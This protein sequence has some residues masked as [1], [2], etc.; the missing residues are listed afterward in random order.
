MIYKLSCTIWL[1]GQIR[2][3]ARRH[4]GTKKQQK[5][6]LVRHWEGLVSPCCVSFL[7]NFAPLWR[8]EDLFS[9]ERSGIKNINVL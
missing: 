3:S 7:L 2:R 4:K 1:R 8:M 6:S 5:N 9:E